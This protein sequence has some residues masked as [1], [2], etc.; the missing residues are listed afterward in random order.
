MPTY[1][2]EQLKQFAARLLEAAGAPPAHAAVTAECLIAANLRG[3]DTH[4]MQLLPYYLEQIEHGELDPAGEG[5]VLSESGA[6][7]LYD[8]RHTLGQVTAEICCGHAVRLAREHGAGVVVARDCCHFGAAAFWGQRI[9]GHGMIG[10]ISCNASPQV[11]PWQGREPR[12][13]TNPLCVATPGPWLLDMAT[14]TVAAG[15]IYKAFINGEPAIPAGWALDAEGRP[16][17]ETRAAYHGGMLMPLGGYKGSGLALMAEILCGVLG[18]G[19]VSTEIGGIRIRGRPMR[20]SHFFLA[21]DIAR[22]LPVDE[23]VARL[24]HLV[25]HVKA[26]RPAAGYDE[27]LVAGDPEWRTEAQRLR[28]GVE[29]GQGTWAQLEGLAARLQV[30]LPAEGLS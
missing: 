12:T 8:G 16:T 1:P 29:V 22:F 21:L 18:G 15:K 27:V 28:T 23:F 14:T 25:A 4:G 3:V 13:G 2:A 30:P 19:A 5:L 11:P 24:E 6:C 26:A 17:T 9:S 7:L 20:V 10:I